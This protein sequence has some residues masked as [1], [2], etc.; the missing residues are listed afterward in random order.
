MKDMVFLKA[1]QYTGPALLQ[2][3]HFPLNLP[4]LQSIGNMDFS[5]PVTF[6]VGENGSGKSTVLEGLAAAIGSVT[7]GAES[8]GADGT[9]KHARI[10]AQKLKLK[11]TTRTHKGFFLRAEDFFGFTKYLSTLKNEMQ[12]RLSE[13]DEEYKDRSDYA[14]S[15]VRMPYVGSIHALR[16]RYGD[17]LDANS[18]GE[19]FLKLF[20]SR[21]VPKGLYILDEPE[22]ALSP[23][24][25]LALIALLKDM[26]GQESQ[27]IIA[28]HSP[29]LMAYPGATIFGFDDGCIKKVA[30]N[31]I[32]HVILTRSFL[33]NPEQFLKHL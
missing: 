29:I 27:F 32:E 13:L 31:D 11:W 14:L 18:H 16:D 17:D 30:Y 22:A 33:N 7:V 21:F 25:Q 24:R 3:E 6:L 19:S 20:Q 28:T 8:V 23:M 5:S 12:E 10:L 9:L 26:V 15:Y 2:E 4:V 1:V